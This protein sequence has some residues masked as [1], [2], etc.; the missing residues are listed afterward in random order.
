MI[1]P[2]PH[3]AAMRPYA[4]AELGNAD[5]ISLAQNESAFPPSPRALTAAREAMADLQLYPDPDWSDL[6][7]AIS[8][9][10]DLEAAQILCGAGSMELI[11]ALLRAYAGPGD[12]IF[13]SEY[14][15]AFA[16]TAAQQ[17]EADYLMVEECDFRVSAETLLER[18]G[19]GAKILFLCN[20]GNPTGTLLESGEVRRLRSELPANVLLVVDE[21]YGE[22]A[23]QQP[24]FDLVLRG[25]T[26]VL[27]SF[28]KAYGLA[29]A[30]VGW[31]YFPAEIA[32]QVRKLLNPNNVSLAS[33]AAA[34]AA[35]RDQ[36]SMRETVS[37]T[38]RVRTDFA[39]GL[40]SLGLTVPESRTNFV[41]IGF[42][43]A[44]E[45]AAADAVLRREGLL[46]RAMAGYGLPQCL[47]ATI[48]Q[49]AV[50]QRC[51]AVLKGFLHDRR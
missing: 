50:M 35:V 43:S 3:V 40:R 32:V 47:R 19:K 12:R 30:R 6:R 37:E 36:A 27:R 20:P 2:R 1:A 18:V 29:G 49:E 9:V 45:A 46:L 26:V 51:L 24:L 16:A 25:D 10:H 39:G 17:V 38:A 7:Y 48:G 21:A 23:E 34:A 33:Q 42:A 22:F 5:T 15:Y 4:L 14:G 41:L 28:S 44:A 31:G 13:G 8:D 11:A